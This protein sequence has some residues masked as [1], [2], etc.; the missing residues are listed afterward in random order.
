MRVQPARIAFSG[1]DAA[2]GAGFVRALLAEPEMPTAAD[3]ESLALHT[4]ADRVAAADITVL[5]NGPT[6][7]GKEVLARSIHLKSARANGPFVAINCAAI[8]ETLLESELFGHEKG[9]FPGAFDR[10]IGALQ[11]ADGGTLALD[12]I[13]RLGLGTSFWHYTNSLELVSARALLVPEG[14][15]MPDLPGR[16]QGRAGRAFE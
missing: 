6:G 12:E 1:A 13:D 16:G 10:H 7:T 4:L 5:I 14:E 15:V 2:V 11:H 9:A 8:P 3:P